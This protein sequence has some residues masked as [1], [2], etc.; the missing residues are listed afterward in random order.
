MS[1]SISPSS[2]LRAGIALLFLAGLEACG[3]GGSSA[4][5]ASTGF[6]WETAL[7]VDRTS[8]FNARNPALAMDGSGNALAAWNQ[9][10]GPTSADRRDIW[11]N[12]FSPGPWQNAGTVESLDTDAVSAQVDLNEAGAGCVVWMQN[13]G[14]TYRIRASRYVPGVGYTAAQTV[15]D[16]DPATGLAYGPAVKMDAA[17]N[18]LVVWLQV[19]GSLTHAWMARA[20]AGGAWS[21]PVRLD[22]NL[23]DDISYVTLA[24]DAQGQAI[25]AWHQQDPSGLYS[26]WVTQ[27]PAGGAWTPAVRVGSGETWNPSV[28]A[29]GGALAVA[30]AQGGVATTQVW[31]SRWSGSAWSPAAQVSRVGS[32]N[33]SDAA[34]LP[35][36]GLDSAGSMLM[37][38][39]QDQDA[40]G[41]AWDLVGARSLSGSA[42][43][44]PQALESAA[45]DVAQLDLVVAPSGQA[46]VVW[47]QADGSGIYSV[48]GFR[49]G[50]AGGF[51]GGTLLENSQA[52]NAFLPKAAI[53][54]HGEAMAIWYQLD[55]NGLR[56]VW[57]SRSR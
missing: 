43:Q 26:A 56:S 12:R 3:G 44:A 47:T 9:Y 28:A 40:T 18:A 19:E 2:A 24:M 41:A 30:Y 52:G 11:V 37:V 45:G 22:A 15:S 14:V 27:A 42:W 17:G 29:G 8:V 20:S 48:Y 21:A 13:D 35:L 55:A 4:G 33:A 51:P 57:A 25:A 10:S 46:V 1:R 23:T 6:T 16:A 38:W 31:A 7:E 53:S 54:S 50:L 34:D 49:G 39:V 36:I 32:G 5:A